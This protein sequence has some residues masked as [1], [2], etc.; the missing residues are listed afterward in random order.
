MASG[1]SLHVHALVDSLAGGG[2]ELLLAEL[3]AVAEAAGIE[4][5]VGYL[6]ERDGS[7]AAERLRA[8]GIE[9]TLVGIPE[10]LYPS[11]LRRVRRHLTAVRP[12]VLHTHLGN[13]DLLGGLAARSLRIPAVSTIHAIMGGQGSGTAAG[14]R[15]YVKARLMAL[16]RR[17]CDARVIAV[18][19]G[20]RTS[21]LETGWDR[22]ERVVTIHNGIALAPRPGAGKA[23]RAELGLGSDDFVVATLSAM[24]PEKAHDVTLAAA[25]RLVDRYPSLRLLVVGDGPGRDAVER[26]A[27][28]LGDRVVLAGYR[29]DVMETLDA[30]DVLVNPSRSDA[31]PSSLLEA[32]AAG[33]PVV[34]SA[35]GGIPEIVD[36]GI[37][38]L[39][40][41]APPRAE[42][43]ADAI[44]RLAEDPDLRRRFGAAA[45]DRF[46]RHFAARHW[47][48]RLRELYEEVV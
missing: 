24:R 42:A 4:L 30:V 48:D 27:A 2:A 44:A 35:V 43:V 9:P 21:Y 34:A 26:A 36:D 10:H 32:M 33:V 23:I 41:D 28:G 40:I 18:S 39:L 3:G 15:E 38:G 19:D 31:F 25:E 45:E 47:A 16:A 13:A 20:A 6:Q 7:P 11:A 29:P 46:E 17:R 14:G 22:P 8:V 1:D 12:Q 37:T 5:S